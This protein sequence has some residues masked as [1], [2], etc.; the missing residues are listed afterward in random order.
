MGFAGSERA[1]NGGE[2]VVTAL[3][4]GMRVTMRTH[5][6]T[7]VRCVIMLGGWAIEASCAAGDHTK[8][9]DPYGNVSHAC[10]GF[11][12]LASEG[13]EWVRGWNERDVAAFKVALALS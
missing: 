5:D 7:V 11:P 8:C 4:D 3:E 13:V 6:K 10:V 2:V 1:P 12:S 9:T